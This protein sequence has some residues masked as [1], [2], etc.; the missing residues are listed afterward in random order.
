MGH[1]DYFEARGLHREYSPGS[2][3]ETM[4]AVLPEVFMPRALTALASLAAVIVPLTLLSL[5]FVPSASAVPQPPS[6]VSSLMAG[7]QGWLE[8]SGPDP[9]GEKQRVP[10]TPEGEKERQGD[11]KKDKDDKDDDD[12]DSPYDYSNSGTDYDGGGQ[13]SPSGRRHRTKW[14]EGTLATVSP[15]DSSAQ[16]APMWD[17]PGG[18][19]VGAELLANLPRGTNVVVHGSRVLN[20]VR[21]VQVSTDDGQTPAGWVWVE[22]LVARG[23]TNRRRAPPLGIAGDFSWIYFGPEAV[24]DEHKDGGWRAALQ[25]FRRVG[26]VGR[27]GLSAG[28]SKEAGK[29]KFNYVTPT[30]IDYPRSS[31]L[32]IVDLGLIAGVD[33]PG[34]KNW[35][36]R[37]EIGPTLF[38]VR[39]SSKMDYDS[40]QGGVVVASG[41]REEWLERWRIGGQFNVG[42]GRV[43]GSDSGTRVGLLLSLF[44]ISWESESRK[45]LTLDFTG[46]KPLVGGGIGIYLDY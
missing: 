21:W 19:D 4:N 23:H 36:I 24:S 25:G 16:D 27:F 5:F 30:Q 6:A 32:Q 40:L 41:Q 29:P 15:A 26:S 39:E 44:V 1:E 7:A 46:S 42:F 22:D 2:P 20:E 10:K 37:S 18:D 13:A 45:S 9:E 17:D 38:W 12:D 33:L 14:I 43:L 11:E 34:G 8:F 28:Y 35:S 3:H 31:R